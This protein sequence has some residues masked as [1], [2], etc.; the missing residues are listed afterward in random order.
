LSKG[1]RFA[2]LFRAN[3]GG[4]L[5]KTQK[6]NLQFLPLLITLS[7][8]LSCAYQPTDTY[9]RGFQRGVEYGKAS[10]YGYRDEFNG[11]KTASGETFDRNSFTA[12]H[13]SLPFGTLCRVTNLS[14]GRSVIVR[15]NDRGPFK[16]GRIVDLSY[17]A[18]KEIGSIQ[19]G[20]ADV[21]VE[22]LKT[23]N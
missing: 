13:R 2:L 8:L 6:S 14:N 1:D 18:A 7:A 12:A 22:V 10:Y 9:R 21:K 3:R 23:G 4:C 19:S 5:T 11:R 20:V 16:A 17:A 15:I